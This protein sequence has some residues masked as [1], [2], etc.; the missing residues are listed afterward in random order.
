MAVSFYKV[1]EE[2]EALDLEGKMEKMGKGEIMK[3]EEREIWH[4]SNQG[5]VQNCSPQGHR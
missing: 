5:M 4:G 1:A 3:K 2:I